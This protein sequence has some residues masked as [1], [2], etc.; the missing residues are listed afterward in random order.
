V[1]K[2]VSAASGAEACTIDE[3]Q[4]RI[5]GLAR[6][7]PTETVALQD[8]LGRMTA[9]HVRADRA[10][11]PFDSS[12]MDGWAVCG[13]DAGLY[14][15]VGESR[16]G[17]GFGRALEPGEA[18]AIST[19]APVPKGGLRVVRRERA[20]ARGRLV[21]VE[22]GVSCADMRPCGCDFSA[23]D[24]LA[25]PGDGIDVLR[26]ALLAAAGIRSV[27]VARRPRVAIIATGDEIAAPDAFARDDQILDALSLPLLLRVEQ[28]GGV[29]SPPST[30]ADSFDAIDAAID[31]AVEAD[32]VI[33]IGGASIGRHDHARSVL[34]ARAF[35]LVVPSVLMKPGKP[36]WC[37]RLA[38]GRVVVGLPG[39]PI[40]ALAAAEL[41]LLPLVRAMQGAR[42][43]IPAIAAGTAA[44]ETE[45]LERVSFA[46]Y[47]ISGSIV[48]LGGV[49]SAALTP[50]QG[51]Q[52]LARASGVAITI[53]GL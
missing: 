25:S 15:V 39:N 1:L 22:V 45:R 47:D 7:M 46:R 48:K 18:I 40:A 12:A 6:M 37:G 14:R 31:H 28:V 44:C 36:F 50:V 35:E 8:A 29:A 38:D 26:I 41:F 3:A 5:I 49:D 20:R 51:A 27:P 30:A 43:P 32:V 34:D 53:S 23:D 16:A 13:L 42:Q 52:F 24:V 21:E 33:L 11:P 9:G 10:Q 17:V 4:A 19:G 2:P